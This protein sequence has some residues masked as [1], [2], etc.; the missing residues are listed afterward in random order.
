M[1]TGE[2]KMFTEIPENFNFCHPSNPEERHP[3]M[4]PGLS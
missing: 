1:E 3:D 2:K 4:R